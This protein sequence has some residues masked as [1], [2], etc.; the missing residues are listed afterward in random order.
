MTEI[1]AKKVERRSRQY[2]AETAEQNAT[3]GLIRRSSRVSSE[4]REPVPERVVVP[5]DGAAEKEDPA[6]YDA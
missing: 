2:D 6:L 1:P 3:S 4:P 5:P